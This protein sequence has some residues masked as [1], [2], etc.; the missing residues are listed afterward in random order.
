MP[1]LDISTYS[2]QIFWLLV[3]WGVLF[4]YLWKFLVPRVSQKLADRDERVQSIL[5]EVEKINSQIATSLE[6]YSDLVRLEKLRLHEQEQ[7]NLSD[8][9]SKTERLSDE[10]KAD[11]QNQMVSY[12]E[13][14]ASEQTAL[15]KKLP[16][17]LSLLLSQKSESQLG[18]GV[19]PD[20]IKSLLIKELG[21]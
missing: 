10:L 1:Q 15:I 18:V 6:E 2:S 20:Q 13:K 21:L 14:V 17:E 19:N 16:E 12:R 5:N 4:V 3:S 11:L 7:T 8:I 9:R